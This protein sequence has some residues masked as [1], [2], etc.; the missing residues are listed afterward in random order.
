LR[1][2]PNRCISGELNIYDFT[3]PTEP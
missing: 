2:I 1:N 3:W